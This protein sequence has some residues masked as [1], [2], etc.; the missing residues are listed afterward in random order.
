M[1]VRKARISDARGIAKVHVDSWL[2]TYRGI[3]PDQYLDQLTYE[4]RERLWERN[5]PEGIVF[6]AEVEGEIVGFSSGSEE[7]SGNYEGFNGELSAVYLLEAHQGKGIGSLL[8]E[9]IVN[10]LLAMNIRSMVVLVLKDNPS[11]FFYE[12][13]G[14]TIIDTLE[15]E[16]AGKNLSELVYGW[17]DIREILKKK[18]S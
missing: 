3:I 9:A 15:I 16:I 14:G 6:V 7:R 1:I 13:L 5:I 18:H 11:R 10:E 2:S 4:N 12:A 8:V 17:E